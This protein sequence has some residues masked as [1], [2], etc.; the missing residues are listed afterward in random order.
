MDRIDR[1]IL[2]VLQA[3]SNASIAD[4]A[5]K[6]GLSLSACH[7][8]MRALE[9][10]GVVLGYGAR[11]DPAKIGIGLNILIDITLVSQSG[12]AMERFERAVRDF[13]DILECHLL[14][15]TADYRVRTAARDMADYDRL[16]RETLARLPGVATMH[17]SFV[18]RTV[19]A[20]AG[21]D[22]R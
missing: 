18:I 14:S 9:E 17:T 4:L 22:L 15:G 3:N 12:E 1:R 10:A 11:L 19:K 7:R 20:W 2:G 16:H 5:A 8:R 21:Y 6:V 13:P